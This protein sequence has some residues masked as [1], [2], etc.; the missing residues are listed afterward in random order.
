MDAM[1]PLHHKLFALMIKK[2]EKRLSDIPFRKTL[3]NTW[4]KFS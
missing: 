4:D 3:S 2:N 1:L